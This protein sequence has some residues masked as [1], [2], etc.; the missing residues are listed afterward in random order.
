MHIKEVETKKD[1]KAFLE[2][3]VALYKNE[4][5][6]IR[7]LD[8]DVEAVFDKKI[9]KYF[10][11]GQC[12]RWLLLDDA[13]KTIG[14]VAAFI[15]NK[16]AKSTYVTC[17]GM[18][19]FECIDD[20]KAAF[21]LFDTCKAW[22]EERGMQAMEGPINFGERDKWWGLL[23]QGFDQEPNYCMPYTHPYY[24][25]FFE[26]YGFQD[27]FKQLTYHRKVTKPLPQSYR[28][29]AERIARDP[30]YSFEQISKKRL[31]KYAEDFR[32][33]YNAAWTKHA[34]VKGMSTAQA[35]SIM[36]QLK[37][38]LDEDIVFFAYHDK[39]P[40]GFFV[41]IP[42]LNQIFKYCKGK[43]GWW[44]KLVFLYHQKRRTCKKMFGV[45]FG[46]IPE[47]QG[48]GLEGAMTQ[49]A[50]NVVQTNG[51]YDDFEM[52]WVGDFNPKIMH[53]AESI[54]STI[55]KTH[56]TYRKIFDPTIPFERA[57]VIK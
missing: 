33:V 8:K 52:N 32:V 14:R 46:I 19:F 6:W 48:K 30:A 45:A 11:H 10:R 43:F 57:T 12:I 50:G 36:N 18:G 9:N 5:N 47:F 34:G 22:L 20:K 17:G 51:R 40:V 37:P 53:V 41:M 55:S 23:V 4:K 24:Q 26:E 15:N 28:D 21:L 13:G 29:K 42:E 2:L 27:Y 54:G 35:M 16:T 38:I 39:Q 3:P 49:A 31:E 56:I 44:Q 25:A 7:P 1:V